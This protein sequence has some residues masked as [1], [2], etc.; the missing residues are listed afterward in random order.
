MIGRLRFFAELKIGLNSSHCWARNPMKNLNQSVNSLVNMV[1]VALSPAGTPI[2]V[3]IVVIV[4]SGRP[5]SNG[6]PSGIDLT[7]KTI[8]EV[9]KIMLHDTLYPNDTKTRKGMLRLKNQ[10]TAR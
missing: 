5:T 6:T 9:I 2:E 7:A 3:Y 8:A 4:I 1:A 10:V